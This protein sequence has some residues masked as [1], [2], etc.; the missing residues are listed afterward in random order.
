[1]KGP[2]D[3]ISPCPSNLFVGRKR[4]IN[5]F[6]TQL[7]K[8]TAGE[9]TS[10]GILLH[11]RPGIG[12]TSLIEQLKAAAESSCYV[13]STEIP[14][15]GSQYFF[16]DLKEEINNVTK[17]KKPSAQAKKR[18]KTGKNTPFIMRSYEIVDKKKYLQEFFTKF[19]KGLD[20]NQK[21]IGFLLWR[22]PEISKSPKPTRT[23]ILGPSERQELKNPL[24]HLFRGSPEQTM[25]KLK[26]LIQEQKPPK[27][28]AVGD[29]VAKNMIEYHIPVSIIVVDNKIVRE[30]TK[31]VEAAVHEVF[32][33]RNPPGT[34]SPEAW[35]AIEEGLKREQLTK[36]L[37]DGEEDLLTL[38]AVALA[39]E[40]SLV[41]YGQPSEGLVAVPVNKETRRKAQVI[42]DAMQPAVE[43][44]K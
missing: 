27:I 25:T 39:P 32:R 13:I 14:L 18:G 22:Q 24:G 3:Y 34:L 28:I 35:D 17:P 33:I 11:G 42:I 5:L 20:G 29:M 12:K 4:E 16:D 31:P 41:A 26:Q 8:V 38:V 2:F 43:K 1:M 9:K 6:K 15:V 30:K 21:N 7:Q 40:N 23:L 36:V 10:K 19:T 37:V 44:A